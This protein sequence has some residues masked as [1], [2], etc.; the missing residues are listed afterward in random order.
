MVVNINIFELYQKTVVLCLPRLVSGC[1]RQMHWPQ[2]ITE[3]S[4]APSAFFLQVSRFE[5]LSN[6]RRMR[7]EWLKAQL[8]QPRALYN[9]SCLPLIV[10]CQI[11][12]DIQFKGKL[13]C[14]SLCPSLCQMGGRKYHPESK[15]TCYFLKLPLKE[16]RDPFCASKYE[17]FQANEW[18]KQG[19]EKCWCLKLVKRT[20]CH[21][22][23]WSWTLSNPKQFTHALVGLR[24]WECNMYAAKQLNYFCF[25]VH[26]FPFIHNHI[27]E[28]P[29][30]GVEG[31]HFL[32]WN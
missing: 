27:T 6:W 17:R 30:D 20:A 28:A 31:I 26:L 1:D 9:K 25:P 16:R 11:F 23:Q 21:C 32:I 12:N 22:G 15:Q 2:W 24:N 5:L 4:A 13:L 8:Y 10:I 18:W 3:S 19:Q 29:L 7:M 14:L